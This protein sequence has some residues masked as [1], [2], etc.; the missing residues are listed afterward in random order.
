MRF[1]FPRL[2]SMHMIAL[3]VIGTGIVSFLSTKPSLSDPSASRIPWER[4]NAPSSTE[5][6]AYAKTMDE[7]KVEHKIDTSSVRTEAL[8]NTVKKLFDMAETKTYELYKLLDEGDPFGTLHGP[9]NF[10]CPS[11]LDQLID[12]P[13]IYD[14]GRMHEFKEGKEG[15]WIMYQHLRKAGGTGFCDLATSNLPKTAIPPYYCMPDNKGSLATPPW[16][17]GKYV[18]EQMSVKGYRVAANEWDNFIEDMVDWPGTVLATTFRHPIDRWFSQYRFEHLERR[19]GGKAKDGVEISA[20]EDL[21][22]MCSVC[23]NK[24][25]EDS[26]HIQCMKSYYNGMRSWTMGPNYYVNTFIGERDTKWHGNKGDFYWTYHKF[27]RRQITWKSFSTALTNLRKF[28]LILVLEWINSS[29]EIIRETLAWFIP[30]KQVLPHE[31]QALRAGKTGKKK[32]LSAKESI[33]PEDYLYLI[34]DN[35]YDLLFFHLAKRI[36]LE[37]IFKCA[38]TTIHK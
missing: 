24:Y 13:S 25:C 18:S 15:T 28:H 20:S 31:S 12:Y 7:V 36:Y 22:K 5:S 37:R 6:V 9:E 23:N 35:I 26:L 17:S 8:M 2:R 27:Q 16:D 3:L 29:H 38:T 34:K 14:Q 4:H 33:P 21:A 19:D 1:M 32:S 10:I 11:E 30:P